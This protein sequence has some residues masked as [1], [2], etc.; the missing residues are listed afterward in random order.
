MIFPTLPIEVWLK[1]GSDR[2]GQANFVRLGSERV[3]PVRLSFQ[4]THTTVRTDSAGT[5]G[6]AQEP[7][8]QVVLLALPTTRIAVESKLVVLGHVLRVMERHPRYT[9]TGV[10]DHIELHCMAW[11]DE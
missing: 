7:T 4:T 9:V 11:S 8:A 1:Q 3:A 5:K 2:Y 10:L 6:H